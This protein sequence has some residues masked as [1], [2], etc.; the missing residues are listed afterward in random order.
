MTNFWLIPDNEKRI[1]DLIDKMTLEEKIGQMTQLSPSI[2]GGFDLPFP[3]LIEMLT[4]GRIGQEE[5]KKIMQ[6]AE[7]DYREDQIRA[8]K[9]GSFLLNNPTKANELQRIA[10]EESRL[11]IPLIFGFDVI[12]GFK[13]VFPIP[14]AEACIWDEDIF[15]QTARI[16]A[17]EARSHNIH[18][19]FS[20]M[21]DVS[22]DAR[23]GRIAESPGEDPFLASVY[24]RAKVRGL[25]GNAPGAD[26]HVAACL[27]H[28]IAYGAAE[29]GQDYNTVSMADS[30]LY[31]VYLPPFQSGVAAGA[32]TV[33]SA[34]NDYNGVPCTI[35]EFLLRDLLKERLGFAGF[36]VSDANSIDDCI[37]H[38][39]TA[40]LE[41][42]ALKSCLA[43]LDMDMNSHAYSTYL[44]KLVEQ[45]DIPSELLDDAVR[46]ILRIKMGLGL[47]DHPYVSQ[48]KM[49]LYDVLPDEHIELAR[50]TARRSIVL[51][52]NE[53][54]ILPIDQSR[55]VAL[56]GELAD[57]P[58]E[59]VGSWA[60]GF[61]VTDCV[62][63]RQGL[64]NAGLEIFYEKTCGVASPF[65]PDELQ[66]AADRADVIIA[67]VGELISMSGE[68]A[69]RADISLPGQQETML[70][71]AL[72]TGKPVIAV[73]MNGRPLAIPWLK[74]HV[75]VIVE[76]WQLGIQMGNAVADVLLG[77]YNPSGKLS[78]TFPAQVGQCPRYYNHPST[79]RPGAKSKFSS[80]YL[81]A[82]LEP[83]F[84]FGFGLSYTTFSYD[85]LKVEQTAD[86]VLA[87]VEISNTG[88]YAGEETVQLYIQDITASL[89]RP[90][91]ELKA[92]TK[93]LLQPGQ[94][95]T[96]SLA[97]PKAH[98]G[99][100]NNTMD[101]RLEDGAFNIYVGTNF[102]DCLQERI[103]IA[104]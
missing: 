58:E 95:T 103:D 66:R 62:S 75:P 5:F 77:D 42:A 28:Y 86:Q 82:P 96:V 18:W 53:D 90:V 81:D 7:M 29:S 37:R 23:W 61:N 60:M 80:R 50:E 76:A 71:A 26:D 102:R 84:P 44:K 78:C 68:A 73:L 54:N 17:R 98:M 52:K 97:V 4:E 40:D 38:G 55:R 83:L 93:I 74:D 20:P 10:V 43:G 51:L 49:S 39:S 1:D 35:N 3:E 91:K 12:H 85:N 11:G 89:V 87:S 94:R 27:K 99:F 33:M 25:Q 15:A 100:Y 34:F 70:K 6:N 63:I 13:T 21:L 64:L 22:R 59:V 32:A 69:S 67:V 30:L 56:I 9:I 45:G 46:R 57:L 36:V 2:V 92:F 41:E 24:A 8:G 47:F 16:S 31:N 88:K 14:L 48:E 101:H 65:D 104:F 19:A 72:K 79:G